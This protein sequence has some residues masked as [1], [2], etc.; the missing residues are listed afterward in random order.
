MA[1]LGPRGRSALPGIKVMNYRKLLQ[2]P[3]NCTRHLVNNHLS[4]LGLAASLPLF[5][6]LTAFAIAPGGYQPAAAEVSVQAITQRLALPAFTSSVSHT[7]YWRDVAIRRGDTIAG[8]LNRIGVQDSE[9]NHFLSASP[10]SRDLLKLKT[11]ATI[12]VQTNDAGELFGLRFLNDDENGEKVL[13]VIEQKNGQWRASADPV[14]TQTIESVRSVTLTSSASGAL[15]RAQVPVEVRAQLSEIFSDQFELSSLTAGDRIRLVYETLLYHGSPIAS[16]NVLAAEIEHAGVLHQAFYFA[17]D[18]ESG[19]YYDASG[20]P[21]KKGFSRQPISGA[22][23]SSGFG[24]RY[25]PILQALRMHEGVDY[26]ASVGTPIVA[27]ADGVVSAAETQNGYGNVVTLRHNA[28]LSTLYA[29]MSNFAAGIRP[30]ARVHAGDVIGY[31]GTTGR[32]TGPHL[33]FEVHIND[34]PVDPA[35]TALPSPGLSAAQRVAF[36]TAYNKL[37][38]NLKLLRDIPVNVA[39][40][41]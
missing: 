31:V 4:W 25:H 33:H 11:G 24:M 21:V 23:I 5:G 1:R 34:Q 20:K 29:H 40:L 38:A 39:Q 17:H 14:A 30:G 7:R 27:P 15:A 32:S 16:G 22:S 28:K 36:H 8:T 35:T 6:T 2:I 26:A 10:L 9:A 13:V 41:D 18:S 37:S 3:Q 12:S 19:A